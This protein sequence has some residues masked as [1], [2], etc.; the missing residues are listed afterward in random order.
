VLLEVVCH[1][2]I[3][4][5]PV[6]GIEVTATDKVVGEG[7]QLVERPRLERACE[8]ALVNEPVLQRQQTEEQVA[9]GGEGDHGRAPGYEAGA[10]EP[11]RGAASH[12]RIIA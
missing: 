9:V 4:N 2:D 10:P 8:L 3:D 5:G 6:V 12:R 1:Q 11:R 7:A